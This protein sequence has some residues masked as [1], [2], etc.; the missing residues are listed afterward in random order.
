MTQP[1]SHFYTPMCIHRCI[2]VG[3]LM[4][5]EWVQRSL[6]VKIKYFGKKDKK[7]DNNNEESETDEKHDHAQSDEETE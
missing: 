7:K 2:R 5:V 6:G 4:Q 3:S 1:F